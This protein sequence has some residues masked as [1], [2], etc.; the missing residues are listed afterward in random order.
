M[1]TNRCWIVVVVGQCRLPR[2]EGFDALAKSEPW[3]THQAAGG[4]KDRFPGRWAKTFF[5]QLLRR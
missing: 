4:E 3:Y 1:T 2:N 5:L